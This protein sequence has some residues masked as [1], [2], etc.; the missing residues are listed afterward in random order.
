MDMAILGLCGA[1]LTAVSYV[2]LI[3]STAR[4]RMRSHTERLDTI[5]YLWLTQG[6]QIKDLVEIRQ[7]L[8]QS[9]DA[10][11]AVKCIR[12]CQLENIDTEQLAEAFS[13]GRNHYMEDHT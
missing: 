9:P 5:A 1:S 10:E 2:S 13:R 8:A 6:G 4:E 7:R 3:I 12:E 11:L